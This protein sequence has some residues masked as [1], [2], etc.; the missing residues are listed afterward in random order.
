MTTTQHLKRRMPSAVRL[1]ARRAPLSAAKAVASGQTLHGMDISSVA[2]QHLT[3]A[4]ELPIMGLRLVDSQDTRPR[5]SAP[6]HPTSDCPT[7]TKRLFKETISLHAINRRPGAWPWLLGHSK[8]GPRNFGKPTFKAPMP[9]E[10][11]QQ[12]GCTF[13]GHVS[14]TQYPFARTFLSLSV[15]QAFGRLAGC[16]DPIFE[17]VASLEP[18]AAKAMVYQESIQEWFR[19]RSAGCDTKTHALVMRPST[20]DKDPRLT[21]TLATGLSFDQWFWFEMPP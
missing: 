15:R 21:G 11:T 5:L 6:T 9:W 14:L 8:F 1:S 17:H 3:N 10:L 7:H 4:Q 13:A 12:K 16:R 20:M 19:Q 2:N 18:Q